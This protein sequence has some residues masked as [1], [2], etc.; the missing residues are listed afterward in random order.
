L[1]R[2]TPSCATRGS[3]CATGGELGLAHCRSGVLRGAEDD[4]APR[5]KIVGRGRSHWSRRSGCTRAQPLPGAPLS[6][7]R[8][9]DT[10]KIERKRGVH[11]IPPQW[12]CSPE[13]EGSSSEHKRMR[14]RKKNAEMY[15]GS[16]A[17]PYV[18]SGGERRRFVLPQD[19]GACTTEPE[20]KEEERE[21]ERRRG[22]ERESPRPGCPS[23]LSVRPP[24]LYIAFRGAGT[25]CG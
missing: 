14:K 8:E 3:L 9:P 10:V 16:G 18:Q 1:V 11:V 17:R 4:T 5:S 2:A 12:P 19:G 23:P 7:F 22:R 13:P 25:S 6:V 15:T 24:P 20:L 21:R